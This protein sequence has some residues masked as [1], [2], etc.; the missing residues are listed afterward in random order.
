MNS[1]IVK[2][3]SIITVVYNG[4]SY[5]ET[6]IT[7]VL[8]QRYSCIEYI[9]ID[10]GSTDGTVNIVNRYKDSISTIISEPD[11]GL[12][13]AMNKGI[14]LATGDIIGILNSDDFYVNELVVEKVV[15]EFEKEIDCLFADLVYVRSENLDKIVRYYDSSQFTPLKFAFGWMPAHPTFFVKKEIYD[16][17]GVFRI[18]L[19]IGADFDILVRFL[20]TYKI[21]YS[22]MQ[23][24][25]VKMRVG[26]VSTS[27]SSIW[28]NNIEA[29]KV[30]RENGIDT[31]IF[32]ILSKYPT[33]F[34]GFFKK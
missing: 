21:S 26:G 15:K 16:K 18:D 3:V 5:V 8:S 28:I 33:K 9:L 27:F 10:G 24:V 29:L 17:Y 14:S 31:N 4:A 19:K 7:S 32:K 2:K 13:D 11:K 12:Y 20:Y 6:A 1:K 22:Y 23:E 25:L 30:C 34:L